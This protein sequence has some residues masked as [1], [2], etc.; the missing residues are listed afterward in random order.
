[1]LADRFRVIAYDRRGHGRSADNEAAFH[2]DDMARE[3]EA[4]L[5]AVVGGPAHLVGWSDGGVVALLVCL[6]RP[7][8]VARQVL[9]GTNFHFDGLRPIEFD[10]ASTLRAEMR[11]AY[12]QR[13]PDGADHYDIVRDKSIAMF[14]DEPTLTL[15]DI[16]RVEAATLV[17]VGDDDAVELTHTTSL[18]EALRAGQLAIIPNAS[19][20]VAK[21][22]P[23]EV[24][25]LVVEFL[26]G[27]DQPSTLMPSRRLQRLPENDS[28]RAP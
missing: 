6:A 7:D 1:M 23:I 12:E 11:L 28:P 4:L 3:A 21:E 8:L 25:R 10:P 26:T 5:D 22:H 18:Y 13:S 16:G 2:Y 9:V 14:A 24:G 20:M 15:D 27:L 19:H 17:L